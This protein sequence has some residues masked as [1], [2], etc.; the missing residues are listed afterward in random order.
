VYHGKEILS[1][2]WLSVFPEKTIV[3]DKIAETTARTR[4]ENLSNVTD[5]LCMYNAIIANTPSKALIGP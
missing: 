3:K 5:A 1:L 4:L 2:L